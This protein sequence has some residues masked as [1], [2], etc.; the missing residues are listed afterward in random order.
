MLRNFFSAFMMLYAWFSSPAQNLI[1]S[2][3]AGEIKKLV[4]SGSADFYLK[5]DIHKHAGNVR[6]S[7]TNSQNYFA[8]GMAS[9]KLE[10]TGN[11]ISTTVDLGF[12]PR[13]SEFNYTDVNKDAA[14]NIS[15]STLLAA[16]KQLYIS[17][18]PF[19]TLKFTVGTWATHIGYEVLDPQLNK[20]YSMSYL[21]SNG[22]F[23]HTGVKAEYSRGKSS[24]MLGLS[25][26]TDYRVPPDG[27]IKKK[28]LI[29]Q[30]SFSV[31]DHFKFFLNYAG[32]KSPDTSIT[33]QVDAVVTA[34]LSK[35]LSA[36]FNASL[37][38]TQ[39]W[40]SSI[41]KNESAKSWWGTAAYLSY[42]SKNWLSFAYRAELFYDQNSMKGYGCSILSHTLS[43]NLKKDELLFIP[44]LRFETAGK[45][46]YA[47]SDNSPKKSTALFLIAAVY[48]F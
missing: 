22:P 19:S 16:V 14:G 2:D 20:N 18:S 26:A 3:S 10:H 48:S 7:F 35:K 13:V 46:V 5:Y 44:E 8:A 31:D 4:V 29:G 47:S 9:V 27:F 41:K 28:F 1:K 32:G 45:P 38:E 33:R 39:V 42:S 34:N 30:Y 15:S 21:F 36:A 17:Y 37:N 23:S 11:K 25:N 43:A 6:T 24:L 12:G 40:N